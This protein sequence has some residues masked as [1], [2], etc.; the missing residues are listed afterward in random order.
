MPMQ[1]RAVK[2]ALFAA[3]AFQALMLAGCSPGDVEFNGKIFDALGVNK[4]AVSKA[5]KMS[6]RSGLVVPPSLEKLPEPGSGQAPDLALNDVRDPDALKKTSQID[7]ERQQAAYCKE[8]YE[9]AKLRGDLS[10]DTAK[11]P[12]GPCRKSVMSAVKN[13]NK[14]SEDTGQ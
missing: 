6:E 5:P 2:G 7:L 13:W 3:C 1:S 14:D 12:M 11:G 4:T 10:A 8:H 9:L